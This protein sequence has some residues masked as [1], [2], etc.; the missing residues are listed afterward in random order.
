[1]K[2]LI[3][4]VIA[5]MFMLAACNKQL[6]VE[7]SKESYT[8]SASTEMATK[9]SIEQLV[10]NWSAGDQLTLRQ[11]N[12]TPTIFTISSG[13]DTKNAEFTGSGNISSYVYALYPNLRWLG[14]F[15]TNNN[16]IYQNLYPPKDQEQKYLANG[17]I[18]P[19]Y[20]GKYAYMYGKST[21]PIDDGTQLP[22][23]NMK[24]IMSIIDVE[25]M[26]L[27]SEGLEIKS[28]DIQGYFA[29]YATVNFD[30]D[31]VGAGE[32]QD[33]TIKVKLKDSDGSVG[34]LIH[35]GDIVRFTIF[36]QAIKK[37][38]V[39]TFSITD[40]DNNKYSVNK[41]FEAEKTFE[42]GKCYNTNITFS[43]EE[44]ATPAQL[45]N[46]LLSSDFVGN[47]AQWGGYEVIPGLCRSTTGTLSD[48][49]W[50]KLFKRIDY[51]RP[52]FLRILT[53]AGW[54]YMNSKK[55]YD[56]TNTKTIS[57]YK[58][59]DYAQSRGIEISY[60]EWGH[61]FS[62]GSAANIDMTWIENSVKFLNYL[63]ETKGYSCIKTANI[64]NEPNG[65]WSST[66]GKYNIWKN[67]QLQYLE[68][69]AKYDAL[70]NI[71]LMGPDVAAFNEDIYLSEW[72]DKAENNLG[73]DIGLYDIHVY[74]G[75]EYVRNGTYTTLLKAYKD[76]V[77]TGKKIVLGELGFK[78]YDDP[79]LDALNKAAIEADNTYS[80][81]DSNMMIY[82]SFYGIDM[83]EGIIQSMMAG[84]S[85]ALA[86]SMDD[87]MYNGDGSWTS[88]QLKRWGF[89]NIAG[90]ELCGNAKDEE[91][92]PHFYSV[93][94]LCR[95][96]P[97]GTDIYEIKVGTDAKRV[98]GILGVKDGKYTIA[99][100]NS[101]NKDYS[102]SLQS[103]IYSNQ[104]MDKYVFEAGVDDTF[105]GAVDADGFAIPANS[106]LTIDL[107]TGHK[108][109]LKKESFVLFT[110]MN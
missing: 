35:N 23:I 65:Y 52:P 69:M 9:T 85:G 100:V 106:G 58:M 49:D 14:N 62:G 1:M 6:A 70:A 16:S 24:N 33:M 94:L 26:G 108:V 42:K 57:L 89:W 82:K 46:T 43:T 71:K 45:T 38:A 107:K 59:L 78:Y 79:K 81:D 88:K 15:G 25:I 87:A 92:R 72:I 80:S 98:R 54:S 56:P 30:E 96:F 37:D 21:K 67:V 22:P 8:L 11:T 84:F 44:Q 73:E 10:F 93:S 19:T 110:N 102:V 20:I 68:E 103:S 76:K 5:S 66:G 2:Y 90:T 95:Y 77:P 61:S 41:T 64:I 63:V 53:S 60:G 104:T 31:Q 101:D 12:E 36:G 55:V 13:Q 51:M 40:V 91:L 18:D 99:L 29:H 47:G 4:L 48:E 3:N 17:E 28:L 7:V 75:Q 74:P 109:D 97:A 32:P 105:I 86:W 34:K 39:W 27:D 83:A 50:N